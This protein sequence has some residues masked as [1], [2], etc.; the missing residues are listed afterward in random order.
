RWYGHNGGA[1]GVN[2]EATIFPDD[3][4][5]IEVLTNRDPPIATRLFG[6]LR[7][8]LLDPVKLAACATGS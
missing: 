2:V 7:R 6:D 4:V 1:P 8:L 5:E 3:D